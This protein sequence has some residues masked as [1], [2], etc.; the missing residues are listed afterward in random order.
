MCV[1]TLG[2]RDSA[3]RRVANSVNV[4]D[5]ICLCFLSP[6]SCLCLS[7]SLFID[8]IQAQLTDIDIDTVHRIQF[9]QNTLWNSQRIRYIVSIPCTHLQSIRLVQRERERKTEAEGNRRRREKNITNASITIDTTVATLLLVSSPLGAHCRFNSNAYT[10]STDP[11][12]RSYNVV[13]ENY[14]AIWK[15]FPLFPFSF[16]WTIISFVIKYH[17]SSRLPSKPGS[18]CEHERNSKGERVRCWTIC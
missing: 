1:S 8:I 18:L 3:T 7:L 4:V 15:D 13:K 6:L 16:N 17:L 12:E 2:H 9:T 11:K 5:E 10:K 14:K